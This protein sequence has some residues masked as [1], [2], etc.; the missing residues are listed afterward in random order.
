MLENEKIRNFCIIAHIDHGKSTLADRLLEVT[1]TISSREMKSQLLDQ[2]DIERERGI[3]IK[4]QPVRMAWQSYELNLIDT[5]GHVDFTYEVSRSLAAVEGA[6][7]LIDATQ[8]I[9]AQ[10]MANL[11]LAIEQNLTIIPVINKID[12]PN[13]Q[14]DLVKTEVCNLIGCDQSE[15][16]LTSGKTG[17]GVPELLQAI[18][19][20]IPPP[21]QDLKQATR[22][23]IFDSNFDEFRG[24]VAEVRVFEGQ[25]KAGDRI[26]FISTKKEAEVLE[27]GYFTPKLKKSDVLNSGEIGYVITGLK[28]IQYCRVGD[29][30]A[31]AIKDIKP[32]AG[33][34]EV[35]PMVF[36]GLFCKEGDDYPHLREAIEKLRLNDASLFYEPENSPALG[37][38]FR[39]GFLG[40]LHLEVIQERL[41]REYDLNLI[42][43]VPSVA[44][45]VKLTDGS[46]VTI[47]SPQELPKP[48]KIQQILEPIMKVDVFSPKQYLGPIMQLVAEKRGLYLNTEYLDENIA[49]LHYHIPLTALLVDFYDKLK[50][51]SSGYA[52]LNYEFL[53]YQK[54]EIVKLDIFVAEEPV[55]ALASLVYKDEAF[56]VG[57]RIVESL[58]AVLPRQM[59]VIKIQASVGSKVIAAER[60]SAMRKDVTAKLYGG[61]YTRKRK[62][63]E[64]QKKGKK[65]MMQRGRVD[66]PTE[67]FLAVLKK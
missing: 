39:C 33:Y 67:A 1:N 56:R 17:Q 41:K 63:L 65:K 48:E 52:S 16:I 24:V 44:Y 46:E 12:L 51:V 35:K 28:D 64:K 50:S 32:L 4:L 36:A 20:R 5:P 9:Q 61:D 54:T 29:T 40:V 59:F 34:K 58:K 3:T 14:I 8:G 25:I 60:L 62:L 22:A 31:S 30:I 49:V 2:M 18:V 10:T 19:D 57:K 66:I 6:L 55:E 13:A 21:K 11:Y 23:L 47:H 27:V 15:I 43:T 7:V 37:F 45:Q 53:E 26:K 38:G 42:I